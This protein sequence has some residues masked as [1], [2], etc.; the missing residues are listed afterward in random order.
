M[1]NSDYYNKETGYTFKYIKE[2][3]EVMSNCIHFA[4][5]ILIINRNDYFKL[6]ILFKVNGTKYK[7]NKKNGI[8]IVNYERNN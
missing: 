3:D 5:D 2:M 7:M 8:Y 1:K 4:S 6:K